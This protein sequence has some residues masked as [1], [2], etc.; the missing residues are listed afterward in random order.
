MINLIPNEQKKKMVKSFYYRLAVVYLLAFG[1]CILISTV[2][3]TP[4]YFIVYNKMDVAN[5]KLEVQK[6]EPVPLPDRE[7]LSV[8]EDLN[9]RLDLIEHTGNDEFTISKKVI[10]TIILK[11]TSNI[12][13]TDISYENDPINGE[14]IS[15]QGTAPSREVL[16]SFRRALE[17]D[18]LFKQV[19]L[20]I[21]NFVKGSNIQFYL[22]L[23][24]S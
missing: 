17:D 4:S 7:T 19:D 20:P 16:L 11:K 13:I 18:T 3:M 6:K 5:K 12:K 8:I 21:S 24:P 9:T 14:K 15:I 23:T 10:N 22:S 1:L 2:V